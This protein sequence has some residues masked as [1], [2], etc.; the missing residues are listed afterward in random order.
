MVSRIRKNAADAA[1]APPRKALRPNC[2]ARGGCCNCKAAGLRDCHI[3]LLRSNAWAC[4]ALCAHHWRKARASAA[5][6]RP[7]V[8]RISQ[9]WASLC[10]RAVSPARE[11]VMEVVFKRAGTQEDFAGLLPRRFSRTGTEPLNHFSFK[12]R[13]TM[14]QGGLQL[15][16]DHTRGNPETLGNF[17]VRR[18]LQ[19]RRD[20][21]PPSPWRQFIQGAEQQLDLFL[22]THDPLWVL[23]FIADL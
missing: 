8:R 2:R 21:N 16:L 17:Q 23:G 3:D 12:A 15:L 20:K 4:S 11:S 10:S 9:S 14:P 19:T 22:P 18:L 13:R 6:A 7:E 5:V 1:M